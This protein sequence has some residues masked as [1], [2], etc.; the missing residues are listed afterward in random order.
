MPRAYLSSIVIGQRSATC[1]KLQPVSLAPSEEAIIGGDRLRAGSSGQS[2]RQ[3]RRLH[4]AAFVDEVLQELEAFIGNA[5]QEQ[6]V[7]ITL[8]DQT[9]TQLLWKGGGEKGNLD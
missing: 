2:D 8:F 7:Q 6:T 5:R 3:S 1:N 4:I 9:T